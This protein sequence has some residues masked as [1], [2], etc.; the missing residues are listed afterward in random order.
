MI[1]FGVSKSAWRCQALIKIN[2]RFLP[3]QNFPSHPL[4][5]GKSVAIV[6]ELLISNKVSGYPLWWTTLPIKHSAWC[7]SSN[8]CRASFPRSC[9]KHSE[10]IWNFQVLT[11]HGR[12]SG[13][14]NTPSTLKIEVSVNRNTYKIKYWW[15]CQQTNEI[16][17]MRS[18]LKSHWC[19]LLLVCGSWFQANYSQWFITTYT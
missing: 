18:I 14:K 8:S 9:S 3:H 10:L 2:A 17:G 1:S 19:N 16:N 11:A 6:P 13:Y 5:D 4:N 7:E 12:P 15:D